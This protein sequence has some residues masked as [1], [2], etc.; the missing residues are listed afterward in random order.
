MKYLEAYWAL[1]GRLPRS[2]LPIPFSCLFLVFH[3]SSF[4]CPHFLGPEI[5]QGLRCLPWMC[6]TWVSSLALQWSLSTHQELFLAQ[7]QDQILSTAGCY[8]QTKHLK[9]PHLLK[10]PHSPSSCFHPSNA[11]ILCIQ[12]PRLN[13]VRSPAAHQVWSRCQKN[14]MDHH[15]LPLYSAFPMMRLHI[16]RSESHGIPLTQIDFCNQHIALLASSSKFKAL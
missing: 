9:C 11:Q 3:L 12:A 6:L 14:R 1:F 16:L 7:S 10:F 8:P 2:F 5:V 4:K 13:G 15:L